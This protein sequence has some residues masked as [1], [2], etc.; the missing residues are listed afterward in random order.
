MIIRE[1]GSLFEFLVLCFVPHA[2]VETRRS[3]QVDVIGQVLYGVIFELPQ[4]AVLRDVQKESLRTIDETI[5]AA[6]AEVCKG[7][8]HHCREILDMC[9]PC[10]PVL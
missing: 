6:D 1:L 9:K 10:M 5:E 8:R 7:R 3:K 2:P 4:L